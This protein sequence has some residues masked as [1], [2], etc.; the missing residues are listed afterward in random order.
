M[1]GSDAE[2]GIDQGIMQRLVN[3]WDIGEGRLRPRPVSKQNHGPINK[4]KCEI[5]NKFFRAEY[6]TVRIHNIFLRV[7]ICE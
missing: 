2:N 3:P 7:N 4:I 1:G 6:I 5:C